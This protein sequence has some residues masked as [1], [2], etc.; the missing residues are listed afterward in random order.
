MLLQHPRIRIPEVKELHILH[1][2]GRFD[3]HEYRAM[4]DTNNEDGLGLMGE[5]TPA[6]LRYPW[7]ARRAALA[8]PPDCVYVAILRDPVARFRSAMGQVTQAGLEPLAA[9]RRM[10]EAVW[11][12]MYADQLAVWEHEVGRDN[13]I[14]W[15]YERAVRDPQAAMDEVCKRLRI[16]SRRINDARVPRGSSTSGLWQPDPDMLDTLR[17]AYSAQRARLADEW[18]FDPALWT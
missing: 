8:C 12:G 16:D 17:I 4:F 10:V 13:M 2:P 11:A 14:V 18:G 6:Y 7:A 1:R 5:F 3:P 9:E 15:Q